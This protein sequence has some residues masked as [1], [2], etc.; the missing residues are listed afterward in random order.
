MTGSESNLKHTST[1]KQCY[2]DQMLNFG[3]MLVNSVDIKNRW[4]IVF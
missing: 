2:L 3:K 1:H 4:N